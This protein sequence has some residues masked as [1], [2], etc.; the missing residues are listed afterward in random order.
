MTATLIMVMLSLMLPLGLWSRQSA[1]A[2]TE[3]L[4]PH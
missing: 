3:S 4:E 2:G 1:A